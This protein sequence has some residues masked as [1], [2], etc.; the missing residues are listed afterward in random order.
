[1]DRISK[2][3]SMWRSEH[4]DSTS[5]ISCIED[6]LISP[7][8]QQLF[9]S[10][11]LAFLQKKLQ[12]KTEEKRTKR[13]CHDNEKTYSNLLIFEFNHGGKCYVR[14]KNEEKYEDIL[15]KECT[16]SSKQKLS[17][18]QILPK[19]KKPKSESNNSFIKLLKR[20]SVKI[21]VVT[22]SEP[23]LKQSSSFLTIFKRNSTT[24]LSCTSGA[25]SSVHFDHAFENLNLPS[26]LSQHS[27]LSGFIKPQRT[28]SCC[29]YDRLSSIKTNSTRRRNQKKVLSPEEIEILRMIP[30]SPRRCDIPSDCGDSVYNG[31][32]KECS[33]KLSVCIED[34]D[35]ERHTS[36][37][38]YNSVNLTDELKSNFSVEGLDV[39][40]RRLMQYFQYNS[41]DQNEKL[42][43]N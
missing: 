25:T 28:E 11:S 8:S 36:V 37:S 33:S 31:S 9:F 4:W 15:K 40:M 2:S 39:I 27:L 23:I 6:N 20:N 30:N 3:S 35:E 34:D 29:S 41:N 22:S 26:T 14:I 19:P 21:N 5:N 17:F 18:D 42:N 38:N 12:E 10:A 16:V 13:I 1:M 32:V 43:V 7:Q 24:N